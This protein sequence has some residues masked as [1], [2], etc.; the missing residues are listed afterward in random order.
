MAMCCGID[1]SEDHHDVAMV[2]TG[3]HLAAKRRITDDAAGFGELLELLAAAGDHPE[4]PVP[5]AIET[6]RG[7]LG[8]SS[9]KRQPRLRWPVV[10]GLA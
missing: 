7:L 3:A 4:A 8:C 10:V 6:A 2:D 5:V 9:V 1:W